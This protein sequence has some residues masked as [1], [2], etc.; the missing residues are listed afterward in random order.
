MHY[1]RARPSG[2][3]PMIRYATIQK[4]KIKKKEKKI[5]KK[6]NIMLQY[7]VSHFKDGQT[8]PKRFLPEPCEAY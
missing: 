7:N 8:Y 5:K 4:Q 6:K 3:R 2:P 1:P